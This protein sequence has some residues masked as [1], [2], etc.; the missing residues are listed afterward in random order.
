MEN[1]DRHQRVIVT[2]EHVNAFNEAISRLRNGVPLCDVVIGLRSAYSA[3]P[4][5]AA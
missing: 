5:K 4:T 1:S 2:R 3:I